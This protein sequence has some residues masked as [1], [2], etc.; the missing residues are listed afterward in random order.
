MK[1]NAIWIF[2]EKEEEQIRRVSLE[3]LSKGKKLK[4][5]DG[6]LVAVVFGYLSCDMTTELSDYGADIILNVPGDGY[7]IYSTDTYT[8]AMEALIR[9]YTPNLLLVGATHNGRDLCGRLAT[10]L[11]LGLAADCT[12]IE[13]EENN[14]A[15]FIRPAYDGKEFAKITMA[16]RPQIGS[17]HSGI[18]AKGLPVGGLKAE[19]IEEDIPIKESALRVK[20]LEYVEAVSKVADDL[21]EA[22]IVV[23]GGRG[24]GGPEGF[25]VIR[26]LAD[27]LGAAVGASKPTVEDGWIDIEHQVGVTGKRIHPKLYIACGISGAVQHTMGMKDSDMIVAINNDPEAPI[28]K[29]AH[30]C[31]V[32]DLFEV[33]PALAGMIRE[34]RQ[35][36][37]PAER[38]QN[39]TNT[40]AAYFEE[41]APKAQEHQTPE[42]EKKEETAA[43]PLERGPKREI[44]KIN[45][46][47]KTHA[48][49]E[50]ETMN[51]ELSKEHQE[52]REMFRE[53]AQMEVKPIAKDLDEK[54]RFPEETIPKLAEAGMLGIPFPEE[55]GGAGM[56]NLAYAMCVEEISK[57]CGS[58]GVIISA[59][60]SLCAWPIFA[61]GTEEQ[62]RKY[63][64]PLAKGEHLGAF[65]LTEPGAGT[66]AAG[67]K[68]TAVL[69]GDHYVLNGSKIF[70][71]NG[72]KADT[73]VIFAMTDITK[74]NHGITAFIV[75]KDFPG[76]SIGKKLDKMGIRGSSTTE[77]IF[78]DCIVPKENLLGEVGKGFKIAMKT[79]D[80]GRIGIAS[81]ALGLAQGA[82]DET[83]PYVK[84]R[85]QFGQPLSAFQNT[86]FQ[87]ANMIARAEG[88]RLLVYQA[89]CAKDAG[90]PYNHLAALAKLVA[91]EAARD[92][93]CEAVQL[94]GGYGF[95]RDYP[96]ERMMRDAKITE[97]YEG[98]SEVQRMVIS[99]WAGVK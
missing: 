49:E 82:I 18:F 3:L 8:D 80:G 31:V 6:E 33:V 66:D 26:E 40:K 44:K 9:R 83:I 65:G 60:T 98:T 39:P 90:K 27:A 53:F 14:A 88:A 61:F 46:V 51:F 93:T 75:E 74:G 24:L 87:L 21:E 70:I 57:V 29:I 52:L 72:G 86:Q 5:E 99:S 77:L 63:L 41:K 96:V 37:S 25:D 32:G 30:Y 42:I 22:D 36:R 89:A 81:Q 23:A 97:I 35:L 43:V 58:T 15:T 79:L 91:S 62:K 17:V 38:S 94:F 34:K 54:E 67:Q 50:E 92:V 47:D 95:T 1:E 11:E 20:L 7:E 71:T 45:T 85:E 19:V 48:D 76:F 84:G 4:H 68:T 28:F 55:Y 73:Y 13:L 69:E 56:D 59:H 78:K 12:E 16:T 10:R 64:V 2:I